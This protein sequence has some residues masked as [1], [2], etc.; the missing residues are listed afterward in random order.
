M[1]TDLDKSIKEVKE[2][3]NS[4]TAGSFELITLATK[5][6]KLSQSI[7][8]FIILIGLPI[9]SAEIIIAIVQTNKSHKSLVKQ[10]QIV[11]E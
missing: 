9:V 1:Q 10:K 5:N 8:S 6:M 7:G 2:Q 11:E 4:T 3:A